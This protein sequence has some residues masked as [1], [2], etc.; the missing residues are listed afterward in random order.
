MVDTSIWSFLVGLSSFE[1]LIEI[2]LLLFFK[3]SVKAEMM[4]LIFNLFYLCIS[5]TSLQIKTYSISVLKRPSKNSQR[6]W[7]QWQNQASNCYSKN[8]LFSFC[9]SCL[10]FQKQ[11]KAAYKSVRCEELKQWKRTLYLSACVAI[12]LVADNSNFSL[13]K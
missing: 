8:I 13:Q 11:S 4:M 5:F 2:Q 7:Q 10:S 12:M 3:L 9:D 1:L 6:S